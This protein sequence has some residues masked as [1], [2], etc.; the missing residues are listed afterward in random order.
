MIWVNTIEIEEYSNIPS[1]YFLKILLYIFPYLCC[2]P[3]HHHPFVCWSSCLFLYFICLSFCPLVSFY[4]SYCPFVGLSLCSFAC[5]SIRPYVFLSIFFVSVLPVGNGYFCKT[6]AE[7]FFSF[8]G[9]KFHFVSL[10]FFFYFLIFLKKSEP[11][12]L[13]SKCH[14]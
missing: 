2:P 13:L 3:V 9:F 5:L 1:T 4:K 12:Q 7:P 6:W 8:S 11:T 10:S 14:L